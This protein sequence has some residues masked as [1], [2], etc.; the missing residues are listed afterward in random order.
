[1]ARSEPYRI[2]CRAKVTGECYDGDPT[3]KQFFGQD[4]PMSEDGT[5][6]GTSIVCDACYVYLMPRTPS[7]RALHH[8]LPAAIE[9][10][11]R[12]QER[13]RVTPPSG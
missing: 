12:R 13:D 6:D 1:M 4:L 8:E 11:H 3:A 10:I 9:A 7:G 2:R 5:F